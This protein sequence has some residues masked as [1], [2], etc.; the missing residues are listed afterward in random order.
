M[1]QT[2]KAKMNFTFKRFRRDIEEIANYRY[3]DK[4]E[5]TDFDVCQDNQPE[6]VNSDGPENSQ[7]R[8]G[9]PGEIWKGLDRYIWVRFS[10]DIPANAAA[11]SSDGD[12]L[13]YA[14]HALHAPG[15]TGEFEGSLFVDGELYQGIDQNHR[16]VFFGEKFAGRKVEILIRF[17]SGMSFNNAPCEMIHEFS[18]FLFCRLDNAVDSLYYDALNLLDAL[19]MLPDF[20]TDALNYMNALERTLDEIDW[21]YATAEDKTPFYRSLYRAHNIMRETYESFDKKRDATVH[22][23]G[24]THIDLAWLWKIKHAR[25]KS[26]R[27]FSTVLRNMERFSDYSFFQSQPQLYEFVKHDFPEEYAQIKERIREGRW[28]ADGAMWVESD[29]NLTGGES[30]VRQIL[31]GKRFFKQEFGVDSKVVWLPDTFGFNAA[32]PQILSKSGVKTFVTSKMCWS[33][34]NRMPHDVFYWKGIDGTKILACFVTTPV[35]SNY[36]SF[37][38]TCNGVLTAKTVFGA[39]DHYREK[40][41]SRDAFLTYGY[42]DGGGGVNR[43]MIENKLRVAKI[44]GMPNVIDDSMTNYCDLMHSHVEEANDVPEWDGELYLESHRGTYTS[45]GFVKKSNRRLENLLRRAEMIHTAVYLQ[46]GKWDPNGLEKVSKVWGILLVNQFHDIVP[47]SAVGVVYD[48]ARKDYAEAFRT[49]DEAIEQAEASLSSGQQTELSVFNPSGRF[50]DD[51]AEVSSSEDSLEFV[52]DGRSVDSQRTKDG[53]LI[54]CNALRP[55]SYTTLAVRKASAAKTNFEPV[56]TQQNG[57]YRT[58]F[59]E[60]RMDESGRMISLFDRRAG[61]EVIEPGRAGNFLQSF[62][63]RPTAYDAWNID[64]SYQDKS[65]PVDN[66]QSLSIV[67][68]GSLRAVI[69]AKWNHFDSVITQDMIFYRSLRRI[70]FRTSVDWHERH[71]LLRVSFPVQVRSTK[72]VYDIPFGNLERSTH[73]NTSWDFARFESCA[74]KWEDLSQTDYGVSLMNDCKYGCVVK[75]NTL[76]LTLIKSATCPDRE[77][78]QGEHEFCYSLLPHA[79]DWKQANTET[80]AFNLNNP[81]VLSSTGAQTGTVFQTTEGLEVDAVKKCEDGDDVLLRVHEYLGQSTTFELFSSYPIESWRET[82]LMEN[83]IGEESRRAKISGLI[84]PYEIKT[85]R[86]HFQKP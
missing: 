37:G 19:E 20:S 27:S 43:D 77:A 76:S 70:D 36:D 84:T 64:V 30:L 39:W 59:Y 86:I 83:P 54:W 60:F 73:N 23:F 62:I 58:P 4:Q 85:Y 25:E 28:N 63:D 5:I 10:L 2:E 31:Y 65:Y 11:H 9:I 7:W 13:L 80:E 78:D 18:Q 48:Q 3:V 74:H 15:Y 6:L 38:T 49:A 52:L 56:L 71:L 66:L 16:E 68:N 67:E 29:C 79:G 82:D 32:L 22:V 81:L 51:M 8:K 14:D 33:D 1:M 26:A 35:I 44:P 41:I 12:W 72:A 53:Y 24:Q 50:R 40:E 57:I 75:G 45:Q 34:Y 17:W 21:P 61:R 55:L 69:R 46:T 47:G 42:G